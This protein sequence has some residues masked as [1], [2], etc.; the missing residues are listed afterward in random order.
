MKD[1]IESLRERS[2]RTIRRKLDK[3]TISWD[4]EKKYFI[5]E[6]GEELVGLHFRKVKI[7]DDDFED[8]L[9]DL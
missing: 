4:K 6:E 7:D 1:F 9:D 2:R 8:D 3:G 5:D